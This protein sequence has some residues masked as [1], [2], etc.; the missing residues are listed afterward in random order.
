MDDAHP[1]SEQTARAR[2]K[3]RIVWVDVARGMA[4]VAMAIYHFAWDLQHFGYVTPPTIDV[5]GW[6]LF[7]RADASSFL[8]LVG[9]SLVLA[10]TPKI[11]WPGFWK[12][13]AMIL[14]GAAAITLVTYIVTPGDFIF[15]GILHSIAAASLIGLALPEAAG[16][17]HAAC[18]GRRFR[19]AVLS[20]KP[21]V[22]SS[23]PVVHRSFRQASAV[24]RLRAPPSL[25]RA[26]SGGDRPGADR[27]A[28]R[29][30]RL[31]ARP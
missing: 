3:R 20:A 11:R 4:L 12:R 1:A 15:F 13:L 8:F 27:A 23:R 22:R 9:L 19:R 18:R 24:E 30:V 28:P 31:A 14:A 21:F 2:P 10:N 17:A 5:G 25:A 26:G 7:A 6:K 29:R 16:R